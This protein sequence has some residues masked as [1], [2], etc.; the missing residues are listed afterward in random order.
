[1][2]FFFRQFWTLV[3]YS[4]TLVIVIIYFCDLMKNSGIGELSTFPLK[5]CILPLPRLGLW[6]PRFPGSWSGLLPWS[7]RTS[8]CSWRCWPGFSPSTRTGSDTGASSFRCYPS[9]NL[10]NI[11]YSIVVFYKYTTLCFNNSGALLASLI[12]TVLMKH[13]IE[14]KIYTIVLSI[15]KITN[16]N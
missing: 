7:G 3:N 12:S 11:K 4:K 16:G 6:A 9:G 15:N 1:M 2:L 5:G 10:V 8:P 14:N 13:V